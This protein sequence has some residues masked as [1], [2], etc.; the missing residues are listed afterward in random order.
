MA[1]L[2][3]LF[4]WF[5]IALIL[6]SVPSIGK[7]IIMFQSILVKFTSLVF[8]ILPLL[9]AF[10]ISTHMIFYNHSAFLGI[11]FS[12]RKLSAMLIGEFDYETLFH[13]K[14][15]FTIAS[16]IFISFIVIMAIVFMNL[17]LGLTV[18]DIQICLENAE[19]KAS[20]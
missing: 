20:K 14:P 7:V 17:L 4:Q 9:I 16:V 13:S 1:A 12:V 5:N 11:L 19:A 8:V 6:R 18:G 3:V 2:S 15:T 10:M